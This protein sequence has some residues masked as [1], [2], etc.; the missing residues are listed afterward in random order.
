MR[1]AKV[2]PIPHIEVPDAAEAF[3]KLENFTR[4]ILAVPKNKIDAS[5]AREKATKDRKKR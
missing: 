4:R 1:K 2:G 3:R 5:L